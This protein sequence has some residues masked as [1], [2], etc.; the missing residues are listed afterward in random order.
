MKRSKVC[1]GLIALSLFA[2]SPAHAFTNKSLKGAW[3]CRLTGAFLGAP[4][5]Q[6][7]LEFSTDGKG[8]I[9]NSGS[10]TGTMLVNL[11]IE[12]SLSPGTGNGVLFN[13]N[14]QDCAY[15]VAGAPSA[16]TYSLAPNGVGTITMQYAPSAANPAKGAVAPFDCSAATGGNPITASYNIV[17]T[18]AQTFYI[19]GADQAKA[20]SCV[21]S[22]N[23][24]TC[25]ELMSG[26]CT[27]QKG[28]K[29]PAVTSTA[30][31]SDGPDTADA[32]DAPDGADTSATPD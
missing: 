5:S 21:G 25:G 30:D 32:P 15:A 11:G 2:Q 10:Q 1:A 6:A 19:N 28:A 12:V 31:T 26:V 23:Y 29:F 27:K 18:N 17:M 20:S 14:S 22:S 24:D 4:G 3:A 8:N 16:S 13:A 7:L 9:L